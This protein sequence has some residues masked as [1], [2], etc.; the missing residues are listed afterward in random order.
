M[1]NPCCK[2]VGKQSSWP[3]PSETATQE[4]QEGLCGLPHTFV[5]W[6]KGVGGGS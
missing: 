3:L 1:Q 5:E 6:L 2:E 4:R